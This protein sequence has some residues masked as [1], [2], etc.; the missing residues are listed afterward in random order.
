VWVAIAYGVGDPPNKACSGRSTPNVKTSPKRSS[1]F[2]PAHL[3][4]SL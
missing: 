1:R 3:H 2:D 4:V